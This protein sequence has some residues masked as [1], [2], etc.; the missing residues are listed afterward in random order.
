[1]HKSNGQETTSDT[2]KERHYGSVYVIIVGTINSE[3][4]V[5]RSLPQ[6]CED[7]NF[8]YK[9]LRTYFN[10]NNMFVSVGLVVKRTYIIS[11]TARKNRRK[12]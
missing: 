10:N 4:K 1:M 9:Q 6:L 11:R 2:P 8:K 5:Y 12:K 7:Y 3:I